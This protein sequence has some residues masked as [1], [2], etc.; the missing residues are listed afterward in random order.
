M[1]L[2]FGKTGQVAQELATYPDVL[3]LDRAA[4]DLSDPVACAAAIHHHAPSAVI[5]A[6]AY[7][8]VDR[9]EDEEARATVINGDSPGAMAMACAERHIP[10]LHVSTDYV[11]DGQGTTPWTPTDA[12]AP[13]NAYGRS[14]AAGEAVIRAAGGQ[15]AILR[16]SWVFSA[17]GANFVKT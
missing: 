4:A 6:A 15:W 14:K 2:V 3:C 13:L 9:A 17:H 8:A 5:N 1:I 16:T 12:I 11:F 7:T 10:F